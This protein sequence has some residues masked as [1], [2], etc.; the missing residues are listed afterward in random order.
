MSTIAENLRDIQGRIAAACAQAGRNPE[1]VRLLPVSKTHGGVDKILEAHA[2]G[3]TLFGGEN[4]VQEA[5][6]KRA[7]WLTPTSGG[8]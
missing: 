7:T 5:A 3:M 8:R 4:R 6:D 2:A 1:E